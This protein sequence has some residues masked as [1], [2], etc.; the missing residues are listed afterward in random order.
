MN[1]TFFQKL[2]DMLKQYILEF[3][4]DG[5]FCLTYDY[6]S[7]GFIKKINPNFILLNN[8]NQFKLDNPPDYFYE[9]PFEEDEY[10]QQTLTLTFKYPLLL[11]ENKRDYEF[12]A[13][14]NLMLTFIFTIDL[15]YDET[16][17]CSIIIP[18]Y[19]H[20]F[21]GEGYLFF[22]NKLNSLNINHSEYKRMENLMYSFDKKTYAY[23]VNIC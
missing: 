16:F 11:S 5:P 18:L 17:N 10:H 4:Y 22:K 8:A 23:D 3:T 19:Y 13:E 1:I 6:R 2:P 15:F 12:M 21:F 7:K 20:K 14:E 9:G